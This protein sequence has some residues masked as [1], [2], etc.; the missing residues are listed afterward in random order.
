MATFGRICGLLDVNYR[1]QGCHQKQLVIELLT[2]QINSYEGQVKA[3]KAQQIGRYHE[4]CSKML[5]QP[6]LDI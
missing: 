5:Q 3:E 1:Y 2:K 4:P 6:G